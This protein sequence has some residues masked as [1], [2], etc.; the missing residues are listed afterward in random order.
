MLSRT[1]KACI[2]KFTQI[3][4]L[5]LDSWSALWR[6]IRLKAKQRVLAKKL[7]DLKGFL[8]RQN[9]GLITLRI[10]QGNATAVGI[11]QI[12][13]HQYRRKNKMILDWENKP[14]RKQE[15]MGPR[16]ERSAG[17]RTF[18]LLML[19]AVVLFGVHFES[20]CNGFKFASFCIC[21]F[22][23]RG[24]CIFLLSDCTDHKKS[25]GCY[26]CLSTNR[27]SA[28]DR[29]PRK[30]AFFWHS[31]AGCVTK[32]SWC[33]SII[34]KLECFTVLRLSKTEDCDGEYR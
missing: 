5:G 13:L 23:E 2:R 3:R 32:T 14:G 27:P 34:W 31:W 20:D 12:N 24:G 33:A 19:I 18:L 7:T 10:L 26:V 28:I 29:F 25:K 21:R 16:T 9:N 15:R 17:H 22:E 4:L 1:F 30:A 6:R 8:N 11:C